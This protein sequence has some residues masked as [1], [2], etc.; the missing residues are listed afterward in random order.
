MCP[1]ENI[2]PLRTKTAY[3]QNPKKIFANWSAE[4][5]EEPL[6]VSTP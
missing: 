1:G 5:I 6:T 3:Q 4:V 2:L